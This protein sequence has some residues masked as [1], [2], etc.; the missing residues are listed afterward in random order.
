MTGKLNIMFYQWRYQMKCL[1]VVKI[2]TPIEDALMQKMTK[3]KIRL[4]YFLFFDVKINF[5]T[6]VLR[7]YIIP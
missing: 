7:S 4:F 6:H 3:N 5:F 1:E 2:K